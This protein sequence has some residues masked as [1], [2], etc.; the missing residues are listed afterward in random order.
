MVE[1]SIEETDQGLHVQY[2]RENRTDIDLYIQ[3]IVGYT[4]GGDYRLY[5]GRDGK[6]NHQ[7]DLVIEDDKRRLRGTY[8]RPEPQKGVKVGLPKDFA[9]RIVNKAR[10]M[11]IYQFKAGG[12]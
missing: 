2:K 6:E 10:D 3:E 4:R 12:K 5:T 8:L 11:N 1:K 9:Q 7:Y